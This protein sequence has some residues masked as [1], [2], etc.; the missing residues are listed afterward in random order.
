MNIRPRCVAGIQKHRAMKLQLRLE[1]D[2]ALR[3]KSQPVEKITPKIRRLVDDMFETMYASN[4]IG[5]AA[6]QVG[7]H[8]RV[9]TLD[10]QQD[11]SR[12]FALINPE[13]MHAEGE[14][15]NLEGCLSCPGLSGD[16]Q[17]AARITVAGLSP[18]GSVQTL[19]I[20]GLLA[21]A[22]QHEIDHLDGILFIDRLEPG[23][24]VRVEQQRTVMRA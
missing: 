24:R 23:E 22:I 2:P 20:E 1:G 4:G 3:E 14:Q 17:R 15:V 13:I 10:L 7:V 5:L 8:V 12:P 9:I 11:G 6:A 16:V 19:E 18:R 21:A